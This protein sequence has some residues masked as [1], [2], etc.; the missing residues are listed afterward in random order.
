M[1]R[2]KKV[3][4][5]F[6]NP[7]STDALRLGTED[8]V[9]H[10]S[11]R[12]SRYRNN[13][14]L[15]VC[16]A[17][18]IHDVRRALLDEKFHIVHISG[19]GTG[20]GLM[21]EDETGGEYVVPQKALG[22]LFAAYCPPLRCVILNACYSV[23]QG[24]LLSTGVPYTIAMEGAISDDAAIEFTRGFYDAIGA[25][26]RIA[27]AYQE[28]CRNVKLASPGKLFVSQLIRKGE[29]LDHSGNATQIDEPIHFR[30]TRAI[31][32]F[33]I[34]VSGSMEKN[35][36]NNSDEK[37]S[38]LQS[39]RKSFER[40]VKQA[41]DGIRDSKARHIQT[42]IDVFVYGFGFREMPV[43]DILS[44]LKIGS[45]IITKQEIEELR[46]RYLDELQGKYSGYSGTKEL[47][48]SLGLGSLVNLGESISRSIGEEKIR[49]RIALELRDRLN[50]GLRTAGETTLSIEDVAQL[51]E[52]GTEVLSN[53]TE[54]VLGNTPMVAVLERL[55]IRFENELRSR[56][57]ETVQILFILSDGEPTDGNPLPIA[58]KLKTQGVKIITCFVTDEDIAQ[59]KT[60]F[61][62][63]EAHWNAGA[64]LMYEMA[65]N[66]GNNSE[67]AKFLLRKGWT[68]QQ[69]PK[70]FVQLNHSE[71]LDEFVRVVLSPLESSENV[72]YLPKGI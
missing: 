15:T 19:H 64:S 21:L 30:E 48:Q 40:L 46:R 65:S 18:T 61:G 42:S 55:A 25:G 62:E 6:A 41:R 14:S 2:P 17:A 23:T 24:K 54:V 60:L 7:R 56:S 5:I 28:G 31:V 3:L 13:I 72:Q 4:A 11:I 12:R 71:T 26:K 8:R 33:A 9:I 35:L 27:F 67:I 10:E 44:L 37:N 38:R 1:A 34:D 70:L 43:C 45:Q 47:V 32:G 22:E 58:E 50:A 20:S 51:W 57:K 52:S 16:H 29:I 66:L 59:P 39:V 36:Q 69:N 53:A 63:E 68:I 49:E